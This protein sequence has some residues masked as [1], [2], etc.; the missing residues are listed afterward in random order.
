MT[1]LNTALLRTVSVSLLLLLFSS[2][3]N[4]WTISQNYDSEIL[5]AKCAK[6]GSSHSHIS[7]KAKASPQN[8]CAQTIDAGATGFGQWGGILDLPSAL[9]NGDEIWIRL[10][11]F[12]PIGFNYDS[13]SGGNRLKFLRVRTFH[14]DGTHLGYDDWYINPKGSGTPFSF[15]YEGV[16]GLGWNNVGTSRDAIKLG[17][18]ETYEYYIKFGTVSVDNRG[19]SRMRAWKNGTLLKDM[20]DRVTF[21]DTNDYAPSVYIFTYWNGGSP[22]TQTMYIDDLVI[23]NEKPSNRDSHGNAYIGVGDFSSNGVGDFLSPPQPPSIR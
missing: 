13:T 21:S 1:Y 15:T 7:N 14:A 17:V 4:A 9:H 18:W 5:G 11:T 12:M 2:H 3:V 22:Q 8:S 6:W 23:T 10:R 20:T 19:S 16:K